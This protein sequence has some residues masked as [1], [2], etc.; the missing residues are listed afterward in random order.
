MKANGFYLLWS[1]QYTAGLVTVT[2]NK[3]IQILFHLPELLMK[4]M[5]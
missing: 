2:P 5:S 1:V 3:K 4:A